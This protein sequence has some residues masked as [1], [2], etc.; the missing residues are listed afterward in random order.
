VKAR[1]AGAFYVL[2]VVAAVLGEVVLHGKLEYAAGLIA[3]ACYVVVTALVYAIFRPVNWA[4]ALIAAILNLAG[5]ALEA[6][7]RNPGGTDVA[8]VFHGLFCVLVGW[9][10]LRS[11]LVPQVLGLLLVLAGLDWL[12]YLSPELMRRVSPYNSAVGLLCEALPF[13]W[14]LVMGVDTGRWKRHPVRATPGLS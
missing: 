3:V 4:V 13:L 7:R 14:L 6:L 8:M 9:L 2:A 10:I 12:L 5:L 11:R 1:V